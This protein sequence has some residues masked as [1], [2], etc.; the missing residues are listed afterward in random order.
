MA[1]RELV[2]HDGIEEGSSNGNRRA[3]RPQRRKLV[4]ED[5]DSREDDADA[6]DSVG[7]RVRDGRD[8][9]ERDEGDLVVRIVVEP[10]EDHLTEEPRRSDHRS[11]LRPGSAEGR[12]LVEDC[13]RQREGECNDREHAV[14]V[15]GVHVLSDRL[16]HRGLGEHRAGGEGNVGGDSA[17]QS[18]P[19]ERKLLERRQR[20]TDDNGDER[21]VHL[22]LEDGAEHDVGKHAGEDGLRGLHGLSE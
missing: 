7:D 5:E 4:A 17:V 21:G 3:N 9:V 12:T 18:F 10:I 8:L 1:L 15:G 11:G 13:E 2:L 22:P 19:C 6:L 20:D 14:Q 16:V